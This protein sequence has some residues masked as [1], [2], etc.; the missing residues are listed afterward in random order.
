MK[1][2]PSVERY[3]I[4]SGLIT[5]AVLAAYFLLMQALGFAEVLEL[6]F[7]NFVILA[8]G[9][10]MAI[11]KYK[12]DLHTREFY[13]QGWAQGIYTCAIA[14]IFFV[15][16]MFVNLSFF[17]TGLMR[18]IQTNVAEGQTLSPFTIFLSVIM[19]GMAGGFVIT[20]GAMQYFKSQGVRKEK[21]NFPLNQIRPKNK[22]LNV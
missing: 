5:G 11:R 8:I 9:I 14:T 2:F 22:S 19:E 16:I 13:L 10:C 20:L 21:V 15:L 17:N 18:Y 4:V 12:K 1:R 6:R 3:G 7:F